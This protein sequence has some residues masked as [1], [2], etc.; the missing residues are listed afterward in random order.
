VTLAQ[1][2]VTTV[3]VCAAVILAMLGA[4]W[5]HMETT[6]QQILENNAFTSARSYS[7]TF[8]SL[9][10][11]YTKEVVARVPR[12]SV[13]VSHDYK[14]I[15]HGIPLPATLT[16]QL[17]KEIGR[18]TDGFSVRL[19]SNY[20]FP[21]RGEPGRLDGFEQ[22][23]IQ[24]LS[25]A[26]GEPYYE[27]EQ[28]SDG[29]YLRYATADIMQPACVTCHNSHPQSPKRDWKVGDLRGVLEVAVPMRASMKEI[30]GAFDYLLIC[31]IVGGIIMLVTVIW[32]LGRNH[33]RP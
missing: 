17:A 12:D 15:K 21:W 4:A 31:F 6:R 7:N 32:V 28:S 11:F 22:R 27:I 13:T 5:L 19:Y 29:G 2:K 10:A 33:D 3:A 24:K 30:M 9:R 20:P 8:E 1:A 25:V 16:I 18:R 14:N 26:P 23:A